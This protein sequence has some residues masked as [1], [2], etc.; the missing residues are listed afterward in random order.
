MSTGK[1]STHNDDG[2]CLVVLVGF[3]DGGSSVSLVHLLRDHTGLGLAEARRVVEDLLRGRC[4]TVVARGPDVA[5]DLVRRA[6]V[7]GALA[8]RVA[9]LN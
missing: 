7:V 1:G 5:K 9:D 2:A 4:V 6:G 3:R 8:H